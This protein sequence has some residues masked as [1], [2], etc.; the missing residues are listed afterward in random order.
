MVIKLE[1]RAIIILLLLVGPIQMWIDNS[2]AI[3]STITIQ[4][5]IEDTFV[6]NMYLQHKYPEQPHG[7]FWAMFAGNMYTEYDSFKG[8]G[9]SRI[10]IKFDTTS[11]PS[12]AKIISADLCLYM[13]DSPKTNQEFEAYSVL[14]EWNEHNLTWI[15]QPDFTEK[16]S[17]MTAIQPT[18]SAKWICWEITEDVRMW[19]SGAANNYGT[20]IR[21]KNEVNASDQVASFYPSETLQEKQL[22]PK[23]TIKIDWHKEIESKTTTDMPSP[24]KE[25]LSTT[26]KQPTISPT[27]SPSAN[28]TRTDIKNNEN[29]RIDYLLP[30]VFVL[31]ISALIASMIFR[32][33]KT[34]IKNKIL[35]KRRHKPR[36]K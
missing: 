2:N 1:S 32:R 16:S 7:Y 15:N 4:P 36:S 22:A 18:P 28:I 19:H 25:Q 27:D 14:S 33:R 30:I 23:L 34:S 35:E 31:G 13:Y 9:S 24:T 6:N 11:I 10:Y 12:D 29:Q 5:S 17:S 26:E 20:M 3:E 8:Y 21:I